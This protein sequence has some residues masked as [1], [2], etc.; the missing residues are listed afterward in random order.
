MSYRA[1]LEELKAAAA[2]A[3]P[4][5]GPADRQASLCMYGLTQRIRAMSLLIFSL[6]KPAQADWEDWAHCIRQK[7]TVLVL[8][9]VTADPKNAEICIVNHQ[10]IRRIRRTAL[11]RR[12]RCW[13]WSRRL[14]ESELLKLNVGGGPGAPHW[15]EKGSVGAGAGDGGHD[16]GGH[17]GARQPKA[18]PRRQSHS[19]KQASCV[20]FL[21]FNRSTLEPS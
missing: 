4:L 6:L 9:L 18:L 5:G 14:F 19:G 11:G 16:R 3:S 20:L 10:S 8:V 12:R 2:Q 17:P 1:M 15:S 13:C 7:R 21:P